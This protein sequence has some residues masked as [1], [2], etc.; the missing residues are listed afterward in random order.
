M[1]KS[2]SKASLYEAK[3]VWTFCR[4]HQTGFCTDAL[5]TKFP[6]IIPSETLQSLDVDETDEVIDLNR[7][8]IINRTFE[9]Y[10]PWQVDAYV[11]NMI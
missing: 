2:I 7:L 9:V 4:L 11:T 3:L 6:A 8:K 10:K 5:P 1:Y